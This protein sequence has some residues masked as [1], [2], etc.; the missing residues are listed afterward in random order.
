MTFNHCHNDEYVISSWIEEAA[1]SSQDLKRRSFSSD[2]KD[3][4]ALEAIRAVKTLNEIASKFS[5]RPVQIGKW[6]KE[7]PA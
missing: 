1:K 4:V 7:L 5:V 3:K 6:K 2:F